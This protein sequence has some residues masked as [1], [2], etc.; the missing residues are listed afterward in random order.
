MENPSDNADTDSF[1]STFTTLVQRMLLVLI[2]SAGLEARRSG[3]LHDRSITYVSNLAYAGRRGPSS[4]RWHYAMRDA[5]GDYLEDIHTSYRCPITGERR[6]FLDPSKPAAHDMEMVMSGQA[7]AYPKPAHRW[8]PTPQERLRRSLYE[9]D[10][11]Q[12]DAA[13][14]VR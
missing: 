12:W 9:R 4:W 11:E 10:K 5:E 7:Y 8:S 1:G 14:G 13:R 3:K 2:G 6:S